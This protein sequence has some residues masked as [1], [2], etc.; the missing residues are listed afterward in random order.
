MMQTKPLA[1]PSVS[2]YESLAQL[3][4]NAGKLNIGDQLHSPYGVLTLIG[5]G[6]SAYAFRIDGSDLVMKVF[7]DEFRSLAKKETRIYRKLDGLGFFPLIHASGE[8][9]FVMDY[10]AGNTFFDC[11]SKGIIVEEAHIHK[12][13]EALESVR[14]RGLN[15][16]DVHLRNIILTPDKQVKI[17]DVARFEQTITCMQWRDLKRS[18]FKWYKKRFFPRKWPKFI[19]NTIAAC[20]KRFVPHQWTT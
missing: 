16:S 10:V 8:G 20:Y 14:K 4:Q 7:Y 13:D 2:S 19:L 3:A 6:R 18:Y 17:I 15:P 11:L 1:E 9:Y 12:V 5:I